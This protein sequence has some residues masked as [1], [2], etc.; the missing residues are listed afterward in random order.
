MALTDAR[1]PGSRFPDTQKQKFP[2][3]DTL[4]QIK[5]GSLETRA[6]NAEIPSLIG[7]KKKIKPQKEGGGLFFGKASAGN[8]E[9]LHIGS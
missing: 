7:Q 5:A 6:A 9:T 8:C 3:R 4:E 2:A 1:S